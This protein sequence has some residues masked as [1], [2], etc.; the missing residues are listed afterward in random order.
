M[1][2]AAQYNLELRRLH[3]EL[4]WIYKIVFVVTRNT[5]TPHVTIFLLCSSSTT[6]GYKYKILA[7]YVLLEHAS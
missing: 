3:I 6:R 1:P 7:V 4:I 5:V 2:R